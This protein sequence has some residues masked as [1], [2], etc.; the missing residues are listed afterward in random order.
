MSE[1]RK[2]SSALQP[3]HQVSSK[4]YPGEWA[5]QIE[6]GLDQ[7]GRRALFYGGLFCAFV[8]AMVIAAVV[9]V[10]VDAPPI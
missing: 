10:V 7:E 2:G 5:R 1:G 6:L 3:S 9:G 4:D 8:V